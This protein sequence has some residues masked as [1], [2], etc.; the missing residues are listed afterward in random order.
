MSFIRLC[1]WFFFAELKNLTLTG[2]GSNNIEDG[3]VVV[4]TGAKVYFNVSL[5]KAYQP[6]VA[7]R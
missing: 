5:S 6:N 4:E 7:Y 3:S 2:K 1:V